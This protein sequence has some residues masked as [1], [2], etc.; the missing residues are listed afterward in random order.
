MTRVGIIG[1]G[2]VGLPLAVEFGKRRPVIG[3]D[4]NPE[5]VAELQ[6][7][8]DDTPECSRCEL[9]EA[10][11]LRYSTQPADLK[12]AQ[13]YTITVPSP[14]DQANHPDMTPLV[15]GSET[16]GKELKK[17]VV[18]DANGILPRSAAVGRL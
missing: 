1:L 18:Y 12:Q 5:R 16:V 14:V 3:F 9:Q 13:V 2:Y 8:E 15:T 6:A 11:Q 7:D 10:K 4:I 17:G